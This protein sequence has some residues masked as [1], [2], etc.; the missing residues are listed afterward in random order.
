MQWY[1]ILAFARMTVVVDLRH[2]QP[3]SLR[4]KSL[5]RHTRLRSGILPLQRTVIGDPRVRKDLAGEFS[6]LALDRSGLQ[7]ERCRLRLGRSR[8][9]LL[10]IRVEFSLGFLARAQPPPVCRSIGFRLA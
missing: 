4:P 6:S 8:T 1:E 2:T 9:A 3:T 10:L 5:S 7:I